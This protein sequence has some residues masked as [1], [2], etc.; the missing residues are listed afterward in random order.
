[1]N[2][3]DYQYVGGECSFKAKSAF[4]LPSRPHHLR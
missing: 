2:L 4:H 1:M 3:S